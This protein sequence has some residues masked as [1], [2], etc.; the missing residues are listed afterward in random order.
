MTQ[1]HISSYFKHTAFYFV[2]K[3]GTVNWFQLWHVNQLRTQNAVEFIFQ[4]LQEM[5]KIMVRL[6][7]KAQ[8]F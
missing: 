5:E 2:A 7:S 4:I 8:I 3:S 6:I 1:I